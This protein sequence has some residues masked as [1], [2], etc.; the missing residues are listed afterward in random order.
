M[1]NDYNGDGDNDCCIKMIVTLLLEIVFVR[2]IIFPPHI[3]KVPKNSQ[4]DSDTQPEFPY[5]K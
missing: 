3:S 2:F 1:P 4:A 5:T